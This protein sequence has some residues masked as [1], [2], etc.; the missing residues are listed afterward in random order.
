MKLLIAEDDLTSRSMLVALTR[1]WGYQSIGVEDGGEAWK[2][3]QEPDAPRLLIVD[4]MMPEMDG[5]TLCR[6][7]R[8]LNNSDPPYIILLTAKSQTADIVSGLEAG[9]NDYIAKPFD[10]SELQARLRV[11]QRMLELQEELN[12]A[13]TKLTHQ[14]LHDPL[15]GVLNRGAIMDILEKEIAKC[16]RENKSFC[17]AMLDLDHF[18]QV[19][20]TYGHLAGDEVLLGFV[21]RVQNILRPYDHFGRFGGEEFLLIG[22]CDSKNGNILLERLRSAIEDLPFK[23]EGQS[24]KATVSIGSIDFNEHKSSTELLAQAD[25]ALYKAKEDGRNRVVWYSENISS[26]ITGQA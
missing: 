2:I 17:V 12:D 16:T 26:N 4:W 18:K 10:N 3:I 14:A 7:I 22:Y 15:T 1:K 21:E 11:G 23:Y 13:K 8:D 24:I 19:N 5:L 6:H 9:A 20:D 25:D